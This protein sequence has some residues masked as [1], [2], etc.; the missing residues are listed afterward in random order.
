MLSPVQ[1]SG[2]PL[3]KS[4]LPPTLISADEV[5]TIKNSGEPSYQSGYTT[6]YLRAGNSNKNNKKGSK[7]SS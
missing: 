3:T 6:C 4:G 1:S 2:E 5:K 7:I